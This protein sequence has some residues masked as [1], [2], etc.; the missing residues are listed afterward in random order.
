MNIMTEIRHER[1]AILDAQN[2]ITMSKEHGLT[3]SYLDFLS[4]MFK[5]LIGVGLLFS[6]VLGGACAYMCDRKCIRIV[7]SVNGGDIGQDAT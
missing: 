1:E 6:C 7:S 4:W 2:Y 5:A 3:N